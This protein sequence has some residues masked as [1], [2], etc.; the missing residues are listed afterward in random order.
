MRH[1]LKLVRRSYVELAIASWN[2]RAGSLGETRKIAAIVPRL[3]MYI[4]LIHRWYEWFVGS[5]YSVHIYP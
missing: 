3:S 4:T 5:L 1:V 2:S